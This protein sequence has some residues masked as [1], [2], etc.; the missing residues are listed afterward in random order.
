MNEIKS[1]PQSAST[2]ILQWLHNIPCVHFPFQ[3]YSHFQRGAKHKTKL[4]QARL[5]VST[6]HL[7]NVFLCTHPLSAFN[8]HEYILQEM[9]QCS[10]VLTLTSLCIQES[11]SCGSG[12]EL[13]SLTGTFWGW[14]LSFVS[15]K[16]AGLPQAAA[17]SS[18]HLPGKLMHFN[19]YHSTLYDACEMQFTSV[20][21][22]T[23]L[24]LS[25]QKKCVIEE[26]YQ[27]EFF[28]ELLQDLGAEIALSMP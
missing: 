10:P 24:G 9:F 1:D 7:I 16:A 27:F 12:C 14:S 18:S 15:E 11:G 17:C 4:N 22:V 23:C 5:P 2:L 13:Q 21:S 25:G 8:M 28:A 6:S 20:S 19:R 3:G 26:V